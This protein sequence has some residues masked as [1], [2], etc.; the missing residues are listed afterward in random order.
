[1]RLALQ[2]VIQQ[3]T[4]VVNEPFCET[5]P[6]SEKKEKRGGEVRWGERKRRE[7]RGKREKEGGPFGRA[8]LDV[9]THLCKTVA[10]V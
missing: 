10:C 7:E 6:C 3:L 1:M 2:D 8:H 5:L 4:D 9:L